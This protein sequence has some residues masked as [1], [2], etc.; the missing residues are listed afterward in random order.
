MEQ[1]YPSNPSLFQLILDT[2]LLVEEGN[3]LGVRLPPAGNASL[4][5]IFLVKSEQGN[6]SYYSRNRGS[7]L[8][9]NLAKRDDTHIPL[10]SPI[11]G[12]LQLKAL[13]VCMPVCVC[14]CVCECVCGVC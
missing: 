6:H 14:V 11:L 1:V 3:V 7:F 8:S 2:P 9:A 5:L 4:S 12:E 13:C 10:V